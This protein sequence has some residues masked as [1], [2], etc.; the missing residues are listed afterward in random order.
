MLFPLKHLPPPAPGLLLQ[1][2]RAVGFMAAPS[3]WQSRARYSAQPELTAVPWLHKGWGM[4]L[5]DKVAPL[6]LVELRNR[7]VCFF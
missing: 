1:P 7:F 3:S 5:P 4:P 6:K 2:L